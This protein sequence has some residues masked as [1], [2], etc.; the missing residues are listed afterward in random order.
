MGPHCAVQLASNVYLTVSV[1]LDRGRLALPIQYLYLSLT[2]YKR[3]IS[4]KNGI[5]LQDEGKEAITKSMR[6]TI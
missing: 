6:K 3:E 4:Q 2:K 1:T 5:S